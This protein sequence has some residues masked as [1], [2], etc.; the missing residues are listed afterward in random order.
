[1]PTVLGF[2]FLLISIYLF[3]R[4]D[5]TL[6]G[7]VIFSAI[8]QSSSVINLGEAGIEPYYLVG[9]VFVLQAIYRGIMG[10]NPTNAFIGKKW[11]ILFC[12]IAILSAFTLPFVFAGVPVYE[13]HVGIDDGLFIRPPLEYKNANLTHSLSLLL[14]VLIVL[15]ATQNLC[16]KSYSK[17]GYIITFYFLVTIIIVQFLCSMLGIEFPY[18]V[19]QNHAGRI[20]QTVD[21]G[22]FSSRYAGTFTE[23]S[24]AGA[25]LTCFTAGFLAERLKVGRSLIPAL[26][27]LAAM[28]L[29]RSSGAIAAISITLVLLL[30]WHPI[31]RFPFHINLVRL[32]R[33]ALLLGIAAT[34]LGV[35]IFSPL[36]DSLI[37]LTLKKQE[38]GSFVN[39]LASDAYALNLFVMTKG[40]G[41]GMGSNRPSSLITSL[42]ST[43]GLVGLIVFLLAYFKLLSNVS[44]SDPELQWAG[45]AYFLCLATSGPDYD[46]PWIWVFLAFAVRV[47]LLTNRWSKP[48]TLMAIRS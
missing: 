6:F 48:Q 26:I 43:V 35:V 27:G 14:G 39:R 38:S 8:F 24:G 33:S 1:M 40:I 16:G 4:K 23:S 32:R 22:D 31:F 20:M 34:V 47:G 21:V 18:S 13:Q 9:S 36:R 11:M 10:S 30:L 3:F 7:F 37:E 29:V 12:I 2:I 17:S 44:T 28:M 25:I 46:G 5:D 45:L 15:G 19:L 42:L 41:V